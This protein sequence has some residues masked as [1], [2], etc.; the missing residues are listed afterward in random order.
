[1]KSN[2]NDN[3]QMIQDNNKKFKDLYE[4]ELKNQFLDEGENKSSKFENSSLT[5]FYFQQFLVLRN[6]RSLISIS[7]IFLGFFAYRFEFD[8]T[9]P[10]EDG[11]YLYIFVSIFTLILI[12]M[13]I[14]EKVIMAKRNS[15]KVILK[16]V[17][18]EQTWFIILQ[19]LASIIHPNNLFFRKKWITEETYN[20]DDNILSFKR[21]FNE[22]LYLWQ[23]T[24]LYFQ[25]LKTLSVNT[26][27]ASDSSDRIVRYVGFRLTNLYI[28]KCLMR[29]SKKITVF[30]ILLS[31]MF[32]YMIALTVVESPL[33]YL[34]F[35]Q[36]GYKAFIYPS[37]ALWN[38]MITL[39]TIG[40]GDIYVVTYFGRIFVAVL[41]ILAGIILSFVTVAMTI[42]FDFGD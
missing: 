14:I 30:I 3:I 31:T 18:G 21:N 7:L 13:T 34:D 35:I 32:Y 20:G 4:L 27:W 5:G 37:I 10:E 29:D 26:I 36:D 24:F 16:E 11:I 42:D 15:S 39:F 6:L 38:T 1:M 25:Y 12:I 19:F 22:Y 17:S 40:Y 33:Y 23:L 9:T 2:I 28:L 41:T 8:Q